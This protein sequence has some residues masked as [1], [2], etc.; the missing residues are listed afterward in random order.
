MLKAVS[1]TLDDD[2]AALVRTALEEDLGT[3][4]VTTL[5]T[6]DA[7]ARAQAL[8][9]QKAPGTIYGLD[10]AEATFTLLDPDSR[11]ERL[12][13]EGVWR[14]PGGAA[15]GGEGTPA[16]P[17]LRSEARR[18]G[19]AHRRAYRAQLPRPPL[20]GGDDGGAR[21]SRGGGDRSAGAR[22][23]QDHP[24]VCGRWR[25]PRWPRGALTTTAW[26]CTT[27]S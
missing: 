3:G 22:H 16:L 23:A 27:R 9:A 14:E 10:A 26:G 5:A 21:G 8:I 20:R 6:V 15:H 24:R 11:F 13:D 12:V 18:A 4:D 17:V 2:L 7:G 1:A 19:A 25:R